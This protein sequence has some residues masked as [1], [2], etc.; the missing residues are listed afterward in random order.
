MRVLMAHNYYSSSSPSGENDA[1]R[2]DIGLLRAAGH[3]VRELARHSDDIT[4][5][6][7]LAAGMGVR[8][9]GPV[10]ELRGLVAGGW[11]PDLVHAHNLFPLVTTA[12]LRFARSRGVPIVHTVH[13]YRRSCAAGTHFRLGAVCEDCTSSRLGLPAVTHGC[14]RGSRLQTLPVV[15]NQ[16]LDADVWRAVDACVALTP[17]MKDRVVADLGLHPDRVVERATAVADPGEPTAPGDGVVYVG[18]LSEEK[19]VD[20]LLRAWRRSGL[21][22]STS[23]TL[24]GDGPCRAAVHRQA[25]DIP[26]VRVAGRLSG[27][28]VAE[29]MRRAAVVVVPSLWYEGFPTVVAEA[30]AHGRAVITSDLPNLRSVVGDC[31]WTARPTEEDLAGVLVAAS[32]DRPEIARRGERARRRYLDEMT[33]E[34]SY[35]LLMTAYRI[36]LEHRATRATES[37]AAR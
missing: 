5:R 15:A 27:E 24:V 33:P 25:A 14:Y 7:V 12:P 18:R 13:N 26:M 2:R 29:Q 19:G 3:D 9:R 35:E 1:V 21:S 23:L 32:G 37:G 17:Y 10:E 22:G 31:G 28:H 20:L 30:F 4:G 36:A 11:R 16:R 8:A 6:R 34:V